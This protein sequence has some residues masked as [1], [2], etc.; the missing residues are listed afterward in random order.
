MARIPYYRS[1]IAELGRVLATARTDKN[2]RQKFMENP[3]SVVAEIGFPAAVN[4]LM[5]FEV[6]DAA[7]DKATVLPYRLNQK[8]LDER[9]ATYLLSIAHGFT[10]IN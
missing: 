6:V 1:N 7:T 3:K 5:E 2:F 8:R 10:S 4:S 9:D